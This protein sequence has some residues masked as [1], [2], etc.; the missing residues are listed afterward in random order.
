VLIAWSTGS[1]L[2]EVDRD[3]EVLWRISGPPDSS[4]GRIFY[5]ASLDPR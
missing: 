5:A 3:H 4:L 2:E 1:L